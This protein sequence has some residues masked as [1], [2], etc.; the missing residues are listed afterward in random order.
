VIA[1]FISAVRSGNPVNVFED[2]QQTRDFVHVR[3]VVRAN[4]IAPRLARRTP[5]TFNVGTGVATPILGL[6]QRVLSLAGVESELRPTGIV[7]K[8]QARHSCADLTLATSYGY[9]P[10]VSLNDGLRELLNVP[11]G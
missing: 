7:E 6:A 2:G 3:D 11:V 9:A 1:K 10:T 5:V 4:L 8:G